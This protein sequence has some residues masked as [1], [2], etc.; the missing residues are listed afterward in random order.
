M[1]FV[2]LIIF[3]FMNT[4]VLSKGS[5]IMVI[6]SSVRDVRRKKSVYISNL[7]VNMQASLPTEIHFS[8]SRNFKVL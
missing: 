8:K 3:L 5:G 6:A 2:N 1:F 4:K 7:S